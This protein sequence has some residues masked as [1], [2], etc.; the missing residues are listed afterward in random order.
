MLG[1]CDLSGYTTNYIKWNNHDMWADVDGEGVIDLTYK[2]FEPHSFI[3]I[4]RNITFAFLSK[5]IYDG[6]LKTLYTSNGLNLRVFI[7]K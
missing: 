4:R 1:E 7:I 3:S 2:W 5:N 6:K